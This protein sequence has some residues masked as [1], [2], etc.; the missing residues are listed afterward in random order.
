MKVLFISRACSQHAGGM[1]QMSYNLIQAAKSSKNL[2]PV[3][4]LHRGPRSLAP[5]FCL[6]VIPQALLTARRCDIVH[7][8]DPMLSLVGWLI[9]KCL[10][11]KIVVSVHGLDILYPNPL[12][13]AYLRLFARSFDLYLPISQAVAG[14]LSRLNVKGQTHV[15]NPGI[16]VDYYDPS[17]NRSSLLK[18]LAS[19]DSSPFQQ[20]KFFL[21][22]GRLVRRKGHAWFISHVLP[23]LPTNIH[24][25]IAGDGPER[26]NILASINKHKLNDRVHLLGRVSSAQLKILYNTADAFVQPN[27]SVPGDMEGFGLVL[28]EASLCNLPVFASNIEG[29]R[30]AVTPGNNG[31]LLPSAD[32]GRWVKTLTDF[33]SS[34]APTQD[35]RSYT[36]NKY[37]WPAYINQL[38]AAINH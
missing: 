19:K 35:T 30:D 16:S 20:A 25:V 33:L 38:L 13:Q 26:D 2:N 18:L 32:S 7:L 37:S 1:E 8:G 22:S 14:K 4:I 3:T 5:L 29:I 27:I 34:P 36:L 12:Y 31:T 24:Y 21:T 11:K 10:N 15:I 17:I 6:F 23:R 9:K 28:L